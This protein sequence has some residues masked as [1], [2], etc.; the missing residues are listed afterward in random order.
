VSIH[1]LAL[2]YKVN[3]GTLRAHLDPNY[4]S[5]NVFNA[6]SKA[7]HPLKRM[8]SFGGWLG[9][10]TKALPSGLALS[11]RRYSWSQRNS[12]RP[13][14]QVCCTWFH[15][16]ISPGVMFAQIV[17]C[18][19]RVSKPMVGGCWVKIGVQRNSLLIC[20]LCTKVVRRR[21]R[22]MNWLDQLRQC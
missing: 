6:T 5:I 13:L 1:A 19:F 14:T 9:W 17:W 20:C 10:P 12:G 16:G 21:E 4:I 3:K 2:K 22:L 7:S 8:S 11:R 18:T 15:G